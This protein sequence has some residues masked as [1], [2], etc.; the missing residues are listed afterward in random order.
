VT[1]RVNVGPRGAQAGFGG[2][3]FSVSDD[4]RY[5]AFDSDATNRVPGDTNELAERHRLRPGVRCVGGSLKRSFSKS[6][7]GGS[8]TTPNF[9]AGDPSVSTHSAAKG[10]M[11]QLETSRRNLGSCRDPLVLGGCPVGSG[12]NTTQTGAISW[13]A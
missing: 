4:G 9:G 2:D 11:I 8:I 7:T 12:L 6:A 10:N 1:Q 5:V 13:S 3:V